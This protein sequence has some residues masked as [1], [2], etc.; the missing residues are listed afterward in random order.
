MPRKPLSEEDKK[1]RSIIAN[2]LK[3]LRMAT[4]E[5]NCQI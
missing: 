5:H 3:K 1:A 2:N 4:Q